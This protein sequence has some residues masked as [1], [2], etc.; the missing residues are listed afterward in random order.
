M[1]FSN[2]GRFLIACSV[3]EE[4]CL[5]IFDV[6]SGLVCENGTSILKDIRVN[7]LVVNPNN[8]QDNDIDFVTIGQ[9][10]S[11][12]IWKYD[13]EGKSLL[14]IMPEMNQDL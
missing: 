3:P 13:I 1:A 12:V 5:T 6:N 14:H 8:S 11:F 7:K 9:Q 10:G 2:C 4:N